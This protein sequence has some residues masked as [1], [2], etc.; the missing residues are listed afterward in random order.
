MRA[1]KIMHALQRLH[2]TFFCYKEFRKKSII[3]NNKNYI[4]LSVCRCEW[5]EIR[6]M[7]QK[8]HQQQQ[9]KQT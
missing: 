2:D 5:Q 8:Q 7:R 9:Q 6:R 4:T 3:L 1:N